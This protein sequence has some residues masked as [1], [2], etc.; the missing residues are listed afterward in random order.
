MVMSKNADDTKRVL[1]LFAKYPVPGK[2][3]TRLAKCIG[4]DFS[5]RLYHCLLTDTI[6]KLLS[7]SL[8]TTVIYVDPP[9]M[10]DSFCVLFESCSNVKCLPQNGVDLGIR[11]FNA[12]YEQSLLGADQIICAGSDIPELSNE[13]LESSFKSL[14]S[15]QAVLGRAMDGGYYLIG[16]RKEALD[17]FF[18]IDIPWSSESVFSKT[19]GLMRINKVTCAVL[20]ELRDLDEADDLLFFRN[21]FSESPGICPEFAKLVCSMEFNYE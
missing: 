5:C 10:A 14:D 16:F 4:H 7:S 18:F 21:L 2:V 13:I 20:P 17:S 15:S 6:N 8:W 19:M 3:K 1:I 9:E 11:M 12:L